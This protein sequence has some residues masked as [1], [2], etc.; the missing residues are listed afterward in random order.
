MSGMKAAIVASWAL[1]GFVAVAEAQLTNNCQSACGRFGDKYSCT[2][3]L[4]QKA[5]KRQTTPDDSL[6]PDKKGPTNG[7][8]S[9]EAQQSDEELLKSQRQL[10]Q[11]C[12][13]TASC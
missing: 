8:E 5:M 4:G 2:G 9:W 11:L 3:C 6:F 10:R 7:L 12:I 1:L 13:D